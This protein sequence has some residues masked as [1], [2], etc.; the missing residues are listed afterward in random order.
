LDSGFIATNLRKSVTGRLHHGSGLCC[1]HLL[2]A[3]P[4]NG[5]SFHTSLDPNRAGFFHANPWH[6][7]A[8]TTVQIETT[9]AVGITSGAPRMMELDLGIVFFWSLLGTISGCSRGYRDWR[10]VICAFA[11]ALAGGVVRNMV[12]GLGAAAWVIDQRLMFAMLLGLIVGL[13]VHRVWFRLEPWLRVLDVTVIFFVTLLYTHR[14][15]NGFWSM[16][17]PLSGQWQAQHFVLLPSIFAG[18]ATSLGGGIC[19]EI[20]LRSSEAL[21]EPDR[22]FGANRTPLLEPCLLA[23]AVVWLTSSQPIWVSLSA[24]GLVAGCLYGLCVV[25]RFNNARLYGLVSVRHEPPVFIPH[26]EPIASEYVN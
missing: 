3:Q 14:A 5:T 4:C 13:G 7:F 20:I 21:F 17:D 19:G 12:L 9:S 15:A 18:I 23:G 25:F 26:V 16:P 11:P 6:S 22:M 8:I 24:G 10:I 1:A 2:H